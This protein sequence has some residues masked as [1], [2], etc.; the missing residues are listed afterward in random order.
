MPHE[1][2]TEGRESADNDCLKDSMQERMTKG[3][4]EEGN[5]SESNARRSNSALS[6]PRAFEAA[7][8]QSS[9]K[10]NS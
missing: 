2:H 8:E 3:D 4:I 10:L 6:R 7:F 5:S 1:E 9:S